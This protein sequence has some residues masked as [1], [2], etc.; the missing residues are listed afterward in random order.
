MSWVFFWHRFQA[1][2]RA[3]STYQRCMARINKKAG[4]SAALITAILATLNTILNTILAEVWYCLAYPLQTG[5][6]VKGLSLRGSVLDTRWPF[7][8]SQWSLSAWLSFLQ[9]SRHRL[10]QCFIGSS[11]CFETGEKKVPIIEILRRFQ[12]RKMLSDR[13][14]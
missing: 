13:L 3:L 2:S 14:S 1:Q 9:I 11:L 12:S 8:C 10:N 4:T 5:F 7:S 6:V